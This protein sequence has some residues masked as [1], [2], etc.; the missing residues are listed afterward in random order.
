M[1]DFFHLH[2]HHL[3]DGRRFFLYFLI[4]SND[5]ELQQLE[6]NSMTDNSQWKLMPGNEFKAL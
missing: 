1:S 4:V 2:H 5:S 6:V 3:N